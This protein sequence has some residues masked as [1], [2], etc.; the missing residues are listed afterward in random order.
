MLLARK[1]STWLSFFDRAAF[2]SKRH[3]APGSITK[4]AVSCCTTD[5]RVTLMLSAAAGRMRTYESVVVLRDVVG[6][7]VCRS[8]T[9]VLSAIF[10]KSE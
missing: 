7:P 8:Q 1:N 10:P 4:S 6:V 5:P 2:G 3:R 9:V